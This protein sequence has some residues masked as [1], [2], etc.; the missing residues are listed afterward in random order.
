MGLELLDD[1]ALTSQQFKSRL[2]YEAG[3]EITNNDPTPKVENA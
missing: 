3:R 2:N 1:V